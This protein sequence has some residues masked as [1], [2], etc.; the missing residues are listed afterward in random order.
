VLDLILSDFRV[1]KV[2]IV[3]KKLVNIVVTG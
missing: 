1:K 2:V 3:P